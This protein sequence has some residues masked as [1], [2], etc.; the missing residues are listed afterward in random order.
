MAVRRVQNRIAESR[1][2]LPVTAFLGFGIWLLCGLIQHQWWIQFVCYALSTYLMV[3]FSRSNALIR[4]YSRTVSASFIILSGVTCYLFPSMEGAITLLCLTSSLFTLFKTFQDPEAVG[5]IFY[6]F[7]LIGLVSLLKVHVFWLVPLY[8]LV[9]A[10]CISSLS[11]RTFIASLI[12]LVLP[13]FY[14]MAIVIFRY[15][16]DLRPFTDHFL[17]LQDL[18]FPYDYTQVPLSHGLTYAFLILLTLTGVIH[19]LRTSYKDKIRTR[20]F[21]YAF[22]LIDLVVFILIAVQPQHFELLIQLAIIVT[23]PLIAHF[24]TLTQTRFTNIAFL[25]IL[26]TALALTGFHLWIS[27]FI[28]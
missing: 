1:L 26:V 23:S 18:L 3:E 5:W 2:T 9:M 4:V 28:S 21:Y 6:T 12:G 17:P 16:G 11:W 14:L 8:W 20:Q 22:M 13:Y 25:V 10:V 24:I 7:L 15:T 27:S 19:F